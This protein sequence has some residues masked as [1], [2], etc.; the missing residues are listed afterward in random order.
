MWFITVIP[1]ALLESGHESSLYDRYPDR[2]IA[3]KALVTVSMKQ[4]AALIP[5][6]T[7]AVMASSLVLSEADLAFL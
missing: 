3:T 7:R 4:M 5:P 2:P 6:H 1:N